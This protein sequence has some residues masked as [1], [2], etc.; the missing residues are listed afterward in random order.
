M[1]T[2]SLFDRHRIGTLPLKNRIVMAP[3][4]RARAAA[5]K[6]PPR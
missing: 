5:G 6:Y 4:T 2:L 3:M 1:N